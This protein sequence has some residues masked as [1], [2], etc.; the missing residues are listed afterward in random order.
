LRLHTFPQVL[1]ILPA[2]AAQTIPPAN[3]VQ[4]LHGFFFDAARVLREQAQAT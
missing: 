2:E 1:D 3:L 4:T